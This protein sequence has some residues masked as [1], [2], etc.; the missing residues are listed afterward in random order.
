MKPLTQK[1]KINRVLDR[2]KQ[3]VA[4]N[5]RCLKEDVSIDYKIMFD[6]WIKFDEELIR[7]LS[8]DER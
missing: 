8:E 5:K 6:L 3:D 4:V 1:E 2:L 7:I